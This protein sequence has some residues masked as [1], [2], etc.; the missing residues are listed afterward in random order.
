MPEE[1]SVEAQV[2]KLMGPVNY[3][4]PVPELK[5][6]ID[7]M[8][9]FISRR[10]VRE[11][12]HLASTSSAV[13]NEQSRVLVA[14]LFVA[15]LPAS[16]FLIESHLQTTNVS[17]ETAELQFSIFVALSELPTLFSGSD[18]LSKVTDIVRR[19]LFGID[20]NASQ[21]AWM[22]GDLLGDHWP[23]S[24]AL[25]VLLDASKAADHV[26]GREGAIH[27]LSHALSRTSKPDQWRII[28]A[29]KDVAA[30]DRNDSVRRSAK[31]AMSTLRSF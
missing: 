11:L 27:G 23:V 8:G 21:A 17:E 15:L 2:S 9:H 29:L 10:L 19:Y 4:T 26:P 22:A 25:P 31:M 5:A 1:L 28:Q 7:G 3:T 12:E 20:T 14:R 13:K 6:R 18:L 24:L 16:L 30:S